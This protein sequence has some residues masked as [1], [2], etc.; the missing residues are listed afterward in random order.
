[1]LFR[2]REW[3]PLPLAA[4]LIRNARLQPHRFLIGCIIAH[5]GLALRFW[6]VAH[7]GAESRTRSNV[8]PNRRVVSGPYS[9]LRHPLYMAN[10]VL[11]EGLAVASGAGGWWLPVLFPV[12]WLLQYYPIMRWEQWLLDIE[13]PPREFVQPDWRESI[14]SERR[15][16]QA[17]AVFLLLALLSSVTRSRTKAR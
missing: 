5:I 6:T 16:W 9:V 12:L 10:G 3:T 8:V 11:S 17:V 2:H 15:T 7:I 1:M 4:W 13:N 14:R